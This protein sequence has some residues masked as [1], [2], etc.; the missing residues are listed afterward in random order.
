MTPTS[1]LG[2]TIAVVAGYLSYV[3]VR[4]FNGRTNRGKLPPGPRGIPPLGNIN[5]FPPANVPEFQHWLKHKDL[6]G[7]ISSVTVMGTTLVIVHDKEAVHDL[8]EINANKTSGRPTN[9][10]ANE[11]CGYENIVL[12]QGYNNTFRECRKLLHR[13]LGTKVSA[14]QFRDVQEIEI[15]RQLARTLDEPEKWLDHL[16]TTTAATILKMTYDYNIEQNKPDTLVS[17][18]ERVLSQFSLAAVPMAWPVDLIPAL[19]YIPENFPG[20]TFK[21]IARKW[22]SDVRA[23]GYTPYRF[24]QRQMAAEKHR[25]SYVSKLVQQ[26][27]PEHETGKLTRQDEDAII[28]TAA[29]LYGA[30]A[31]TLV[32]SLTAFTMAMIIFPDVQRK[33]QEELDRV[34]G[35]NRFPNFEDREKLPYINAIVKET[36]RWWSVTPMG[37]PHTADGD[38]DYNDLHIPKGAMILPAVWWF[39]NDPE[40]YPDPESFEPERFLSPRSEPDPNM[41]GFFGYGRRICPGRFFA[42]SSLYLNVAQSL[43]TFNFKKATD[44]DGREV[45]IDIKPKPGILSYPSDFQFSVTARSRKHADLIRR[46]GMEHPLE[47]SDAGLLG[48]ETD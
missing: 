44:K 15:N 14:A 5:D 21:K 24:V 10:F 35:L 12:C 45:E 48:N 36:L 39:L 42:D 23:S 2:W 19:R 18:I 6:Y 40:V 41:E 22:R 7:P 46:V 3:I 47:A 33:A 43:A 25:P 30:A 28:W 27:K 11:L 20:F 13:E 37:F 26:L 17:L 16:K 31:D 1:L 32:I 9:V 29:S 8:L 34:V 38:V 4:Y